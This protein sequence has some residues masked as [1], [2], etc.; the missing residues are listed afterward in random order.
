[1]ILDEPTSAL[2]PETE[3]YLM[4]A[5]KDLT[6]EKLVIVLAH[7]LST[8]RQATNII[9][10]EDGEVVEQGTHEDLMKI[11]AGRYRRFVDLQIQ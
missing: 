2:D 3:R 7:R 9:F 6:S 10:L 5:L 1:M 8:I 11:D 4:T